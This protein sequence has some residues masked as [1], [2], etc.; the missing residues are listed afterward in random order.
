MEG[1]GGGEGII[2]DRVVSHPGQEVGMVMKPDKVLCCIFF[3]GFCVLDHAQ[4]TLLTEE[5]TNLGHVAAL[6]RSRLN[7]LQPFE[8]TVERTT[9]TMPPSPKTI[10]AAAMTTIRITSLRELLD[11]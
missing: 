10:T 9:E 5:P 11:S 3:V 4:T 8:R 6:I 7:G 2:L 1:G